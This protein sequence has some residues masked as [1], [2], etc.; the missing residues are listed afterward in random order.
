M[1]NLSDRQLTDLRCNIQNNLDTVWK[2]N[3]FIFYFI[4]KATPRARYTGFGKHFYVS[5][6]MNNQKLMMDFCKK[7][8]QEFPLITTACRFY[9]DTYFP[10]PSTMSKE[11]KIRAE[12]KLIR[13]MSKPDWDNIGKT[14]SDMVQNNIIL[15]DS[16]IVDGRVSKYYST[17]P[18]MKRI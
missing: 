16:I 8:L 3:S 13:N 1:D 14:Y 10:T 12:L 15:D 18:R 5:D 11:E 17:K 4:P 7:H 6:A 2:H 9:C